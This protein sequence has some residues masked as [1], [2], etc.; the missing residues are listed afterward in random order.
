MASRVGDLSVEELKQLI[1][2]TAREAVEDA[3]EDV[4]AA[5]SP[6]F[7]ESIREAR[8]DYEAG[9]VTPLESLP[10]G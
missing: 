8:A 7:V 3:L 1:R 9:K 4:V 2:E 6:T 10:R 5:S